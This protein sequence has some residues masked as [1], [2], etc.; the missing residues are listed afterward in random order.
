M[1]KKKIFVIVII[2]VIFLLLFLP[3]RDIMQDGGTVHYKA[4][5]YEVIKYH[6]LNELYQGGFKTGIELKIFGVSVYKKMND[7]S[8]KVENETK[9]K[10]I[11]VDGDLYYAVEGKNKDFHTCSQSLVIGKIDSHVDFSLLPVKDNQSNFEGDYDYIRV[12]RYV[13]KICS[14]DKTM[15]FE[16]K[17]K[18]IQSLDG[19]EDGLVDFENDYIQDIYNNVNL[20]NDVNILKGLYGNPGQF[21]NEYILSVGI[22]NLVREQKLVDEEYIDQSDVEKMIHKIFG[23]QVSFEHQDSYVLSQGSY[24]NGVCGYWYRKEMKKYQLIHGCGG[25][26]FESFKRKLIS[27]E[28]KGDYLYLNEKLIYVYNDWDDYSS[29]I[30]IYN[31]YD[32]EKLLDYIEKDSSGTSSINWQDY[33]DRGSTYMYIFRKQNDQYI[34]EKIVKK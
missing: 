19:V 31:N 4:L 9:E 25:N 1:K 18:G 7:S 29:R 28:K 24:E 16:R 34:F 21:S 13:I 11:K 20:S 23:Y 2:I 33:L 32:K 3:R 22:S 6:Q 5:I 10:I 17:R 27:V 26:M 14:L 30:Y 8:L 15:Y 12:N